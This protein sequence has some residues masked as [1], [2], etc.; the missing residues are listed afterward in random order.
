MSINESLVYKKAYSFAIK[1]IR[2]FKDLQDNREYIMSKQ[3]LRCG[4]SV[5]AN[6][7]EA[8]GAISDSDF[9][10]KISIAYKEILET[11]YWLSL[12]MDTNYIDGDTYHQLHSEADEI[13]KIL[14]S[15]LK[16]TRINKQ[17]L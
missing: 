15:I 14:F 5:G 17:Q 10:S 7:A 1:I 11:K 13:A 12:L 3:L 16:T 2:V 8:N 9:S 6:I 4:T